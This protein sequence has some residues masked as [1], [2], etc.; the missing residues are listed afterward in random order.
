MQN[1]WR[2]CASR[3]RDVAAAAAR[4]RALRPRERGR[5]AAAADTYSS[6]GS[7]LLS[8]LQRNTAGYVAA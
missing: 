2:Q 4:L 6:F 5:R 1:G 7:S 3:T 8:D